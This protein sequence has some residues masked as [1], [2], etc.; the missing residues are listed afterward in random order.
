MRLPRPHLLRWSRRVPRRAW[1]CVLTIVLG[2]WVAALA[3]A[4]ALWPFKLLFGVEFI[5]PRIFP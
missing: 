4:Y 1:L 3:V 5:L 2:P